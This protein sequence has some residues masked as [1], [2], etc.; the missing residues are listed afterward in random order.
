MQKLLRK[1]KRNKLYNKNKTLNKRPHHLKVIT[2]GLI[3]ANW[4]GHC[5]ALKPHWDKMKNE[6]K[7]GNKSKKFDFVEIEDSDHMKEKKIHNIN[8]KIKGNKIDIK[9]YPTI[10]KIEGGNVKYYGG[11]R[12][13]ESLKS[14]FSEGEN[15]HKNKHKNQHKNQQQGL[16]NGMQQMFG[17]G[18]GCSSLKET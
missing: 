11:E 5:Q 1:T 15:Q 14:W 6:M 17:G 16:M 8:K 13:S 9:G 4:C 18:C 10:F 3:H 12:E 2:V 7:I